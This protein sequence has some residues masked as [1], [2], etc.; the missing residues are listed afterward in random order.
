MPVTVQVTDASDASASAIAASSSSAPLA[1]SSAPEPAA[2]TQPYAS[3]AA[4]A[5]KRALDLR[6]NG[7][8]ADAR[9]AFVEIRAKFPYSRFAPLSELR[10]ADIDYANGKLA[11]AAAE[12]KQWAHDHR[13]DDAAR[14]RALEQGLTASCRSGD[15]DDCAALTALDT[16]ETKCAADTDCAVV[17]RE[18][19][20]DCC[21]SAPKATRAD[22]HA[23]TEKACAVMS[24]AGCDATACFPFESAKSYRAACKAGKCALVRK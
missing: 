15:K 24:C 20:C 21:P 9:A 7:K 10:I 23:K 22:A 8:G 17:A 19:C 11:D 18:S 5:Y 13:S 16:G 12:W 3:D 4:V 2:S 1:A 14:A 6:A